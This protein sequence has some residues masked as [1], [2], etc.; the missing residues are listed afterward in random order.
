MTPKSYLSEIVEI[1]LLIDP[2]II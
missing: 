1:V 2:V